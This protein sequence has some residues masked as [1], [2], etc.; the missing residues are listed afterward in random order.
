MGALHDGHRALLD[1]ARSGCDYSVVSIFVNPKQFGPGE[2]LASYPRP[3]QQDVETCRQAGADLVFIPSAAEMYPPGFRT[4]VRVA[5][6]TDGLC[7][8]TRPGHFDG[9]TT[10][11]ARLFNIIGPDLAWFGEKDY[12]QLLVVR[13]LVADLAWPIEIVAHPTVRDPDGLA[14]SSRNRYLDG[15]SRRQACEIYAALRGAAE[16]ARSGQ[17]DAASLIDLARTRIQQAGRC[18][19]D[20]VSLVDAQTLEAL[21]SVDRPARLC[22]AVRIGP[23]R[24]I[25]NV[26]VDVPEADR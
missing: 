11:V 9:V 17:T 3:R 25:D 23:C 14:A 15:P 18:T 4:V 12:Q 1:A 10:V 19:I 22:A 24:L 21:S 5:G 13:Q 7:G 8:A 20:Y 2:D 6:L 26:P 16:R